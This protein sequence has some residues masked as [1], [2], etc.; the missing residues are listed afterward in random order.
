MTWL[1]RWVL[2][3]RSIKRQQNALPEW[4]LQSTVSGHLTTLGLKNEA[5][6]AQY[7]MAAPDQTQVDQKPFAQGEG[8]LSKQC[9]VVY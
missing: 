1:A 2:F 8:E 5:Q 4:H 9:P 3:S 6:N 7:S